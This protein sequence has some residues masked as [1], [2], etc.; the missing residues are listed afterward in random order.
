MHGGQLKAESRG[1]ALGGKYPYAVACPGQ[2]VLGGGGGDAVYGCI[3]QDTQDL[4]EV[5]QMVGLHSS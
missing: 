2:L 4:S 5:V 1:P 3:I